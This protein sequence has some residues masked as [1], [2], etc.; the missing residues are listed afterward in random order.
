[1]NLFR[2]VIPLGIATY[3]IVWL[4]V[5]SGTRKIKLGFVWHR[6]LGFIGITLASIHAAVVL[7][8]KIF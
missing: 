5:L 8:T 4:S 3:A 7:Y 2:L 6:R 1:M